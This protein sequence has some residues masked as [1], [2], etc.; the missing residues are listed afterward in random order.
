MTNFTELPATLQESAGAVV[1][2]RKT[3]YRLLHVDWIR[4]VAITMVV[5]VHICQESTKPTDMPTWESERN[6]GAVNILCTF[7][8]TIFFFCCGMAQTFKRKNWF[9]FTTR[10]FQR[11][12]LPFLIAVPLVLQPAQFISCQYGLLLRR[13]NCCHM[14][15]STDSQG[16]PEPGTFTMYDY[17]EFLNQWFKAFASSKILDIFHWLWFLPL[18]FLTD[19]L[20]FMGCRWMLFSFEGGWFKKEDA[21]GVYTLSTRRTPLGWF[22]LLMKKKDVLLATLVMAVYHIITTIIYPKLFLYW[23]GYWVSLMLICLGLIYLRRTRRWQIWWL[24]K[25][26]LPALSC[27]YALWWPL[28][29]SEIFVNL[30]QFVLFSQQGYIQQLVDNFQKAH[31][32]E[33]V[34]R[35]CMVTNLVFVV[36]MIAACAPTGVHADTPF[37]IPMYKGNMGLAFLATM[38]NWITIQLVDSILRAYYSK[39]GNPRMFFHFTQFPMILYIYHLFF[40]VVA[41]TWITRPMVDYSWSY[42]LIFFITFLFSY[43]CCGLMYALFLQFKVTRYLFG[44]RQFDWKKDTDDSDQDEFHTGLLTSASTSPMPEVSEFVDSETNAW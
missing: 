31:C 8:I 42:P 41:T 27:F 5:F 33:G 37:E 44:V 32:S 25:K 14:Y 39:R 17:P 9:E 21:P 22:Q 19:F 1:E 26:I 6:D 3:S 15:P 24:V 38:G 16:Y 40:I 4:A 35:W 43:G 28:D 11:L 7:G 36:F 23:M 30:Q 20:S 12:I 10:R 2:V 34:S 13:V 29:N 18:M